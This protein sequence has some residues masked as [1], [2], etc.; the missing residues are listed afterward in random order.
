MRSS[1]GFFLPVMGSWL[2]QV[3]IIRRANSEDTEAIALLLE[4]LGHPRTRSFLRDRIALLADEPEEKL[5]VGE[6]EGKVGGGYLF[7][8][9]HTQ[10]WGS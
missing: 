1:L 5:A 4:Q 7:R 9:R 8:F 3:M 6:E 2:G 10:E